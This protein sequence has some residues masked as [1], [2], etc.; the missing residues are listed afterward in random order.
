MRDIQLPDE[1]AEIEPV[2]TSGGGQ[3]PEPEIVEAAS[4]LPL[5]LL[6]ATLLGVIALPLPGRRRACPRL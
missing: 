6:D 3:K 1:D 2:S 4:E 5:Q